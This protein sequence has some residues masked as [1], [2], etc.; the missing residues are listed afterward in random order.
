MN[1]KKVESIDF[2]CINNAGYEK[3]L[4]S[5]MIDLAEYSINSLWLIEPH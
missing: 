3:M 2:K 1:C 4:N 5:T